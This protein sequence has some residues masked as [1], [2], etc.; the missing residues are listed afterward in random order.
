MIAVSKQTSLVATTGSDNNPG[1]HGAQFATLQHA[2]MSLNPGDTLDVEAGSYDG[3][4][5]GWDSTPASGGDPYGTID[6]TAGAP[7]GKKCPS[8]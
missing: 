1:T 6:G 2:M 4:I 7:P 8:K 5:V 3:F